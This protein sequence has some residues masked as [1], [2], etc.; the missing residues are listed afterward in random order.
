MYRLFVSF[1]VFWHSQVEK[2][3]LLT[4]KSTKTVLIYTYLHPCGDCATKEII[5][6]KKA[7]AKVYTTARFVLLWSEEFTGMSKEDARRA[8]SNL[9]QNGI[10]VMQLS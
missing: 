8:Q 6:I 3:A 5:P 7:M 2:G 1:N 10:E 4:A 9:K